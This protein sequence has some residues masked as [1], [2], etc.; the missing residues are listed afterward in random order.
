MKELR[1]STKA[2][3]DLKKYRNNPRKMG[4]LYEVLNL[5]INELEIPENFL[6]HKWAGEYKGCMECNIE[7][8]F[9]LIG[10]DKNNQFIEIIRIGS[11]S[12]LFY[13]F[14]SPH[15][16]PHPHPEAQAECIPRHRALILRRIRL[17][18]LTTSSTTCS[19]LSQGSKYRIG[20]P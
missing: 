12:E 14:P 20:E 6:P 13:G 4:K 15:L 18:P 8:D 10:Y 3:K 1:Y 17:S 2:K 5:L 9:R 7:G 11:H 16:P 19:P